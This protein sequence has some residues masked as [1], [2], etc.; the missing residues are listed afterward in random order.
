MVKRWQKIRTAVERMITIGLIAVPL[1]AAAIWLTLHHIP[2]WYRPAELDAGGSQKARGEAIAMADHV[3]D[4]MVKRV[5]FDVV[6]NDTSVT[7]WIAVL[8]TIW[9]EAH[10]RLPRQITDIAVAFDE[11]VVRIGALYRGSVHTIV[12]VHL[13]VEITEYEAG[14]PGGATELSV[15]VSS[16]RGGSLPFSVTVLD[17]IVRDLLGAAG[18]AGTHAVRSLQDLLEGVRVANRFVWFNGRRP[19]RIRSLAIHEGEMRLRIEP[20]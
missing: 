9:P 20:L 15:R 10:A 8:P 14:G 2:A 1:G 16:V 13:E 18:D 5:P 12:N 17:P 7:E 19:F 11:N 4:E 6:L 3:S